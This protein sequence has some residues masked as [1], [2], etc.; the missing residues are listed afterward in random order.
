MSTN[1]ANETILRNKLAL[2][3]QSDVWSETFGSWKRKEG[4]TRTVAKAREAFRKTFGRHH[5]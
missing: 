3:E 1:R 5:R 4:T 2:K